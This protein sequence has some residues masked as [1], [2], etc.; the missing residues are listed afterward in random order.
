M[1]ENTVNTEYLFTLRTSSTLEGKLHEIFKLKYPVSESFTYVEALSNI[2][3]RNFITIKNYARQIDYLIQ[4]LAAS[5]ELTEAQQ[6]EKKEEVFYSGL[7]NETK[8]EITRLNIH[9]FSDIY[10]IIDETEKLIIQQNKNTRQ[11]YTNDNTE[12]PHEHKNNNRTN[13][14]CS[15]HKTRSHSNEE[16]RSRNQGNTN[17]KRE[18]KTYA[19]MENKITPRNIELPIQIKDHNALALI[20]TGSVHNY[21]SQKTVV[22]SNLTTEKLKPSA[23]AE[24]AN[25]DSLEIQ[26]YTKIQFSIKNDRNILYTDTFRIL[27][28]SNA[29]IILGMNFL[30]KN[31]VIINLREKFISID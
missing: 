1:L 25:G 29:D 7:A 27:P 24:L 23:V 4:R 31:D 18:S 13:K 30:Q 3:Q 12:I 9:R 22:K 20:D 10:R 21:I 8:L 19:L 17:N 26:H 11:H 2:K 5:R 16:C 28:D 15:L 14:Y 6:M